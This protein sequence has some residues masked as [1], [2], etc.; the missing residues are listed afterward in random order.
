MFA[1]QCYHH[2]VQRYIKLDIQVRLGY[3]DV[4]SYYLP[5]LFFNDA[6]SSY[7]EQPQYLLWKVQELGNSVNLIKMRDRLLLSSAKFSFYPVLR[8]KYFEF[9]YFESDWLLVPDNGPQPW[10]CRLYP[11]FK[12]LQCF[13]YKNALNF[14]ELGPIAL[15]TFKLLPSKVPVLGDL[16]WPAGSQ[17]PS[18]PH[19]RRLLLS[20][21]FPALFEA[22]LPNIDP[23]RRT[24]YDYLLYECAAQLRYFFT[25]SVDPPPKAENRSWYACCQNSPPNHPIRDGR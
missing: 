3:S 7:S 22:G 9:V 13:L 24:S 10:P 23:H 17:Q 20:S 25:S 2:H 19:P 11:W 18:E 21:H 1:S 16:I 5:S 8:A 15:A 4:R 14:L 6:T 12:M